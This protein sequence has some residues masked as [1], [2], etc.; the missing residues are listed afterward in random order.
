MAIG[1]VFGAVTLLITQEHAVGNVWVLP[2]ALLW[3]KSGG[4]VDGW[5]N[6]EIVGPAFYTLIYV[7]LMRFWLPSK[8]TPLQKR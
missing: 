2:V 4:R 6:V 3:I 7:G 1:W 5:V 8:P